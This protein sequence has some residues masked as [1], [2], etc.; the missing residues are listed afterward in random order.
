MSNKA[1]NQLLKGRVALVTGGLRPNRR[2]RYRN[3]LIGKPTA[4]Y[5]LDGTLLDPGAKTFAQDAESCTRLSAFWT[6]AAGA[7]S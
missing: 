6:G 4:L 1:L 7:A 2:P 3:A 5:A